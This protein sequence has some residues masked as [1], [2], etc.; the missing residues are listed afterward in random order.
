[1]SNNT[2]TMRDRMRDLAFQAASIAR[3][4]A[5]TEDA[6]PCCICMCTPATCRLEPCGHRVVCN[7]DGCY[8][9]VI[10]H[11]KCPLCRSASTAMLNAKG[12][13]VL[14]TVSPVNSRTLVVVHVVQMAC[15]VFAAVSTGLAMRAAASDSKG[16][17]NLMHACTV[18]AASHLIVYV[19]F[20]LLTTLHLLMIEF[21]VIE[22]K[23]EWPLKIFT[24]VIC[25]I[26][27]LPAV[28][29]SCD[30]MCDWVMVSLDDPPGTHPAKRTPARTR[31]QWNS[32]VYSVN[33]M[34]QAI[35]IWAVLFQ[36][37]TERFQGRAQ[38]EDP[39][40]VAFFGA[41]ATGLLRVPL[42][43]VI[44]PDMFPLLFT[45]NASR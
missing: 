27:W 8:K 15:I 5:P 22:F 16:K 4:R 37:K 39:Y 20:L 11:G 23:V 10:K 38:Y 34:V 36:L 24:W 9:S 25:V 40:G 30:F 18:S 42:H 6:D 3:E 13:V 29:V 41:I 14:N 44:F 43:V 28:T 7:E 45:A 35:I 33:G 12:E 31:R 1:M 21:K 32:V 2:S 19:L 26:D 17:V